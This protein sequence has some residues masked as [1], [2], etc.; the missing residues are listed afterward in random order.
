MKQKWVMILIVIIIGIFMQT[1]PAAAADKCLDL[2]IN[3]FYLSGISYEWKTSE[4][5][6][7]V[8]TAA[9]GVLTFCGVETYGASFGKKWYAEGKVLDGKYWGLFIAA[10]HGEG[11]HWIEVLFDLFA[12]EE[13]DE[14][15]NQ[16]YYY[17]SAAYGYKRVCNS[18][19]SF[20]IRFE[21]A[22][23]YSNQLDYF[24]VPTIA[25]G[26]GYGW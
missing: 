13:S 16:N 22:T 10:Y 5:T 20:D 14:D 26:I 21:L 23:G 17:I 4:N 12:D 8:F 2:G 18:G 3:G 7:C 24:I 19:I 1:G 11:D 9:V 6:T 25:A 15:D